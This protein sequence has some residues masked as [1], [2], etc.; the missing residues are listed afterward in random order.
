[1]ISQLDG[2]YRIIYADPPWQYNNRR[3][4]GSLNSGAS[5]KYPVMSLDELLSLPVKEVA[6]KDS[7]LFLWTTTPMLQDAFRVMNGWGFIYKTAL[8]WRKIMS[9]G[10]GFWYRGQV[11]VCLVGVRGK[12]KAF[13]IQKSNFVQTKALKHSEK[14]Q[15]IRDLIEATGLFPRIE[16]FARQKVDGW[17]CWGNEVESDI[18]L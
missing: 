15:E 18:E 7:A 2:K 16:L 1:M 13:R 14:P 11:E 10:M 12:V 5:A 17:D 4:G 3:T 8:Y 6:S 9:L